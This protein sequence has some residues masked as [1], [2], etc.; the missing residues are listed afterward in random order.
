MGPP[1]PGVLSAPPGV[2]F[3][4]FP[5]VG[6]RYPM[7]VVIF[8]FIIKSLV[9]MQKFGVPGLIYTENETQKCQMVKFIF[10]CEKPQMAKF[11]FFFVSKS[12]INT[13]TARPF[14]VSKLN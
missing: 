8:G 5:K 14:A 4:Y 2:N 9:H 7:K 12:A 10:F 13:R 6:V 11:I 3:G 1:Y